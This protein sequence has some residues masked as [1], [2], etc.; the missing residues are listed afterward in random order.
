MN[1]NYENGKIRDSKYF[2]FLKLGFNSK[3]FKSYN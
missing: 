1:E 2:I 3:S